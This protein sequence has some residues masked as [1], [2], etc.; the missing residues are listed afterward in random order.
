MHENITFEGRYGRPWLSARR[1]RR[2]F[3][4]SWRN[5]ENGGRMSENT[6]FDGRHTLEERVMQIHVTLLITAIFV[7]WGMGI[8]GY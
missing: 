1:L 3:P 6:T 5:Y 2:W 8:M 4:P 7:A